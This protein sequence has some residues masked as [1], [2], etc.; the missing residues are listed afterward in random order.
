ML[1][2]DDFRKVNAEFGVE[3]ADECLGA[4]AGRLRYR[5]PDED[6]VSRWQG[7]EFLVVIDSAPEGTAEQQALLDRI[8]GCASGQPIRTAAGLIPLTAAISARRWKVGQSLDEV[9][10]G[11]LAGM[12]SAKD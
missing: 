1:D 11:V 7:D 8:R 3:I 9:I 10:D 5:L 6:V 12:K 4:I 2:V